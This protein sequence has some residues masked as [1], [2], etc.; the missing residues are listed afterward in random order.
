MSASRS[1]SC[2]LALVCAPLVAAAGPQ[3]KL[4]G[5]LEGVYNKLTGTSSAVIVRYGTRNGPHEVHAFVRN[6]TFDTNG[7][8]LPFAYSSRGGVAGVGY[9]YYLPGDKV[10]LTASAAAAVSDQVLTPDYRAGIVAGDYWEKGSFVGD[11]YAEAF[12]VS[13]ADDVYGTVRLRPG[14][15]LSRDRNGRLWGYAVLQGWASARQRSGTEN[16]VE[17]GVGAGYV[18]KGEWSLNAEYRVGYSFAGAITNKRYTNPWVTLSR[19]F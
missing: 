10:F 6:E 14:T 15:I 1:L 19:S 18:Y 2:A 4:S 5:Y 13:R 9:R 7:S 8:D 3:W 17:A 11:L 12:W 16:K